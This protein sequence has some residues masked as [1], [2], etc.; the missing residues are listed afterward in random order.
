MFVQG[1]KIVCSHAAGH[2][3]FD[4]APPGQHA[5]QGFRTVLYCLLYLT[6]GPCQDGDLE[7]LQTLVQSSELQLQGTLQNLQLLQD[8]ARVEVTVHKVRVREVASLRVKVSQ[9][10]FFPFCRRSWH[11]G[12]A[13][14]V[15]SNWRTRPTS[16]KHTR[17]LRPR[18]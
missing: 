5:V 1:V 11:T 6:S 4:P 12:G 17:G 16:S 2:A 8:Y 9:L 10:F 13:Q 3:T 7:R 15:C 18:A 14:T